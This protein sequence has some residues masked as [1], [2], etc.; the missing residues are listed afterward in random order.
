MRKSFAWLLAGLTIL[1][2]PAGAQAQQAVLFDG[3]VHEDGDREVL[4]VPTSVTADFYGLFG[5]F[6]FGL[7]DRVNIFGQA[8]AQFNGG[9]TVVVGGGWAAN[10]YRQ[11]DDLGVNIGL[12]NSFLFPI[13]SG[14]PDTLI[15]L[16]PVF[17]HTWVRKKG[18][19]GRITPYA[20]VAAT[21]AAGNTG[22]GNRTIVNALLGLKVTGIA[23]NLNFVAE[24]QPGEESLFAFGFS[25]R[26]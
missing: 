17:S 11:S 6:E 20:G 12:F 3:I 8:G 1:F 14:G 5:R 19:R 13:E 25:Y 26:F 21:I 22:P 23:D 16:A 24:V 9:S 4:L 18:R 15:T 10:L 7:R 2:I